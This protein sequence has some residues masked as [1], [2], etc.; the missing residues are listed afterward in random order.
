M[1]RNTGRSGMPENKKY[2]RPKT[3]EKVQKCKKK[4]H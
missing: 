1:P 3:I 2:R 4:A